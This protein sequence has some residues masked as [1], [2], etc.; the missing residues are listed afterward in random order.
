MIKAATYG[1]RTACESIYFAFEKPV[2]NLAYRLAQNSHDAQDILQETFIKLFQ[3]MHQ[4]RGQA[5]FWAWLRQIALNTA[6]QLLRNRQKHQ[7]KSLHLLEQPTNHED[8]G[9]PAET[10]DHTSL[11][12]AYSQLSLD[13]RTVL[14]LYHVEGFTHKEIAALLGKTV[15]FSKSQLSRAHNKLRAQLQSNPEDN[16]LCQKTIA[17]N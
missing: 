12:L 13:N 6:L 4:Y 17:V 7:E 14:W 11:Y 2:Y 16:P 3:C 1:N 9:D 5:P 15:S 10:M 8:D